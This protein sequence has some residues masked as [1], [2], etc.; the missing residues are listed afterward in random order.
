[1]LWYFYH[2][3]LDMSFLLGEQDAASLCI[4]PF[5]TG[6]RRQQISGRRLLDDDNEQ[7]GGGD[8]H[9]L[10]QSPSPE[11]TPDAPKSDPPPLVLTPQSDL[12]LLS[13]LKPIY[14]MATTGKMRKA[15]SMWLTNRSQTA[16]ERRELSI[17]NLSVFDS[18]HDLGIPD[19]FVAGYDD[20]VI[21]Y[22]TAT[23]SMTIKE[24]DRAWKVAELSIQ[25][26]FL[27]PRLGNLRLRSFMAVLSGKTH[28]SAPPST[29]SSRAPSAA[30]PPLGPKPSKPVPLPPSKA[31]LH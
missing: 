16:P 28:G 10:E 2:R 29:R 22:Q 4:A 21:S 25:K 8:R 17:W 12:E 27:H 5:G 20:F 15:I 23:K 24:R 7:K 11:T 6:R 1:M 14:T 26:C 19:A 18:F 13:K 31:V 30:S 3:Q 9:Y